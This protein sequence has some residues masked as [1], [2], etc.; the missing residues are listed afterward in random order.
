GERVVSLPPVKRQRR[1]DLAFASCQRW[2]PN[3]P[4]PQTNA[5][6]VVPD[7][8]VEVVSPTDQMIDVLVKVREYFQAGVQVVWLVFP[9]ERMVYVYQ[10]PTQI[11]VLT[12]ADP[13]DGG[14][15]VPG[16]QLPL[17]TLFEGDPAPE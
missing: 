12:N 17:A 14:G 13:L 7:L 10:S 9:T 8:A 4:V 6:D 16:V 5:W 1:P 2:P 11:Q 3:K 15:G